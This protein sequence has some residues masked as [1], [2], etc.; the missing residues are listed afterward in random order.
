MKFN[1]KQ[2]VDYLKTPSLKE[3]KRA[4]IP[5]PVFKLFTASFLLLAISGTFGPIIDAEAYKSPLYTEVIYQVLPWWGWSSIWGVLLLFIVLHLWRSTY[6]AFFLTNIMVMFVSVTYSL[7]LS[8]AKFEKQIPLSY[9]S[10]AIWLSLIC[11][12]AAAIRIDI[13]FTAKKKK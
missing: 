8:Y 6:L 3:L 13:N 1:K 7:M 2:A 11:V 10:I 9:L 4:K 5:S 12:S